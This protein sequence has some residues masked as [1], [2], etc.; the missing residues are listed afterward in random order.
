MK[1]EE[2]PPFSYGENMINEILDFFK[3]V[4]REVVSFPLGAMFG[5]H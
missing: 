2:Y 4:F 5:I 1:R 3:T